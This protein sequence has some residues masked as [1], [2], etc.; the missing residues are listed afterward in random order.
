MRDRVG[1]GLTNVGLLLSELCIAV[2]QTVLLPESCVHRELSL[3]AAAAFLSAVAHLGTLGQTR[4]VARDCIVRCSGL[5]CFVLKLMCLHHR[6][7]VRPTEFIPY[8]RGILLSSR[9]SLVSQS[10]TGLKRTTA[11]EQNYH[12]TNKLR[13]S[14]CTETRRW[15]SSRMPQHSRLR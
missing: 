8:L 4:S 3:A 6:C 12:Q 1:C 7:L 2:S 14:V 13:L 11:C 15:T 5:I 9:F 10:D